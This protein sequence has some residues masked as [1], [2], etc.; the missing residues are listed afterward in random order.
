MPPIFSHIYIYF[1]IQDKLY[2]TNIFFYATKMPAKKNIIQVR[3]FDEKI[4]FLCL[5]IKTS[6]FFF[7]FRIG[8][9]FF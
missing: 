5:E 3:K 8:M 2:S 4:F 9:N 1:K 6:G 7:F